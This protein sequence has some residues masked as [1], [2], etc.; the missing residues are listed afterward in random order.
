MF[1]WTE[2]VLG[3]VI[4]IV[5]VA[6]SPGPWSLVVSHVSLSVGTVVRSG[7]VESY[8]LDVASMHASALAFLTEYD[9]ST[10][11]WPRAA[12][13]RGLRY[14]HTVPSGHRR[15]DP[16]KSSHYGCRSYLHMLVF[17]WLSLLGYPPELSKCCI[18][19][20]TAHA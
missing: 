11:Y 3:T 8:V 16:T 14:M 15:Q 9:V 4:V 5:R 2:V 6:C 7:R 18:H 12:R 19:F 20:V 10:I 13:P 1:H 17:S